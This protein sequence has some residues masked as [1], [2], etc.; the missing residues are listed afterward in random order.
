MIRSN[1]AFLMSGNEAAARGAY[2][3]GVSFAAAYPGTPSTRIPESIAWFKDDASADSASTEE[4]H[5][6]AL[7]AAPL[8]ARKLSAVTM[9]GADPRTGS[10]CCGGLALVSA[11]DPGLH[12]SQKGT[13]Q[14]LLLAA[15]EDSNARG[16]RTPGMH[17]DPTGCLRHQRD[18]RIRR[19]KSNEKPRCRYDWPVAAASREGFGDPCAGSRG[20]HCRPSLPERFRGISCCGG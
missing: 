2:D 6:Q 7:S 16:Q 14:P 3:A 9:F 12:S 8:S 17:R 11:D 18:M 5:A 1:S 13:R 19:M 4:A 20:R 15:R 10:T